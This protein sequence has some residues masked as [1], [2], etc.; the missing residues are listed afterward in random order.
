MYLSLIQ[1]AAL[2]VAL[3]ALYS[4]FRSQRYGEVRIKIFTGLLFGLAAIAGMQMPFHYAPGI[5]YD[6]RSIILSIGGLFGGGIATAVSIVV[7]GAYRASLG[8]AG[9]WA[10]LA[11]I[12]SC[13][14]IG[15]AFRR[16]YRNR[17]ERLS[18]P[19]L[20]GVGIIVHIVM[21]SCQLLLPSPIGIT[22]IRQ[23]WLPVM[24]IF[25]VGTV[26]MGLM[27]R[28]EEYRIQAEEE[29]KKH[30]EHLEELVEERTLELAALNKELASTNIKLRELDRLKSMFIASMSH[31]LRTPLNSI[32]GFTGIILQGLVGEINEE[33]KKQLAIVKNSAKHLLDLIND[34]IDLS[35]IEAGKVE[36][37]IEEFDLDLLL[38]EV[39]ETLKVSADKKGLGFSLDMPDALIMQSDRRRIKQ[40]LMNLGSNAVKYTDKG[41]VNIK[42][43]KMRS[44]EVP[45][46]I[47]TQ[48]NLTLL[49]DHENV[50][51]I[52]VDDTGI[53]IHSQD[54]GILFTAFGRIHAEGMPIQEGTGLGL[55]LSN[56][57]AYL[58]G[59]TITAESESGKGSKFRFILPMTP[60]SK[61][62]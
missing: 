40:V 24:L 23:I 59:G 21:L 16:V 61:I 55:Y 44:S 1:N 54:M 46:D 6:G 60:L 19:A 42:V 37:L 50:I 15:L 8:G 56:K 53:G 28:N 13:A 29:L 25:P 48:A 51:E 14:I 57:L 11:T 39:Y 34:V 49:S 26:L 12:I 52:S 47:L 3:T 10:G 33:Q 32:I 62:N 2:L 27:L 35:K 36:L 4:L 9:V 38:R 17:P 45:K 22:V 30:R 18:I 41:S 5:I 20:Y 31:E 43:K 58:L 7:T